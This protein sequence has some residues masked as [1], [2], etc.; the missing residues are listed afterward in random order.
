[1]KISTNNPPSSFPS[2]FK[3]VTAGFTMA[4]GC[5]IWAIKNAPEIPKTD[6]SGDENPLTLKNLTMLTGLLLIAKK[7]LDGIS[8]RDFG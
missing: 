3:Y 7:A 8:R 5:A 2:P 4:L 1:M 6:L